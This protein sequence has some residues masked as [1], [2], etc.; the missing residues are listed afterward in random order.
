[1]ST[2]GKNRD[3]EFLGPLVIDLFV[4]EAVYRHGHRIVVSMSY[5]FDRDRSNKLIRERL[6]TSGYD[7]SLSESEDYLTLTIDPRRRLRVPTTNIALFILT[8]FSVYFVPVFVM[9]LNVAN[10]WSEAIDRT[11]LA[12]RQGAGIE[13]TLAIMSILFIHEMGHYLASRRR[14]IVTSWPYFIPAPNLIGTFGAII[15][16][17]SPF[18]NRRDLIEVG[19]AGP[20]AGWV[21]AIGWLVYG[22]SQS[23]ILPAAEIPPDML[24]FSMD[25]ES[26]LIHFMV[27]ILI[28][29]APPGSFYVFTEAA[30]AGWVGLLI[31]AIN[32][33]PIGQLDGGHILYGLLRR[34]QAVLGKMAMVGLVVMGFQ[35]TL[36]WVFAA[37][38]LIFGVSHPPTLNDGIKPS[39]VALF[40]GVVSILILLLSFTPVPFG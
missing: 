11:L 14:H 7:F 12:L 31:T 36:W 9:K 5:R 30:F 17:K 29:N 16:S 8:L 33:L 19:A 1:M 23:S 27:P 21:V 37:F 32:L 2:A 34:K 38:G 10:S 15:K 26:F 39:P 3:I 35:S 6:Q 40:L 24:A 13:F 28:G 18:W 20:I 22:L 25:G 4:P